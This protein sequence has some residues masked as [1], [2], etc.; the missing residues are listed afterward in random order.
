MD[1]YTSTTSQGSV[2]HNHY[3]GHTTI[4]TVIVLVVIIL[5]LLALGVG[6]CIYFWRKF[7]K[8]NKREDKDPFK[9]EMAFRR[10]NKIEEIEDIFIE[11][12]PHND[13][14]QGAQPAPPTDH[15]YYELEG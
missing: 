9:F 4:L 7:Q 2:I 13:R 8:L 10:P 1:N 11:D 6:I 12:D 15:I 5:I 3:Y 14:L